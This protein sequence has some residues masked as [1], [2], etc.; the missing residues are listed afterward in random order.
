MLQPMSELPPHQ[1][2]GYWGGGFRVGETCTFCID[3]KERGGMSSWRPF[4]EQIRFK[5]LFSFNDSDPLT[6][7]LHGNMKIRVHHAETHEHVL[8][9]NNKITHTKKKS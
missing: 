2:L 1:L 5:A 8:S 6:Y 3:G 7:H 4:H 9:K